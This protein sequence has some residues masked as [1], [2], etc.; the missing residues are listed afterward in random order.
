MRIHVSLISRYR[1]HRLGPAGPVPMCG[2]CIFLLCLST[3]FCL[4]LNF[5]IGYVY[6]MSG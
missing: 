5:N 3:R 4:A 1:I 6:L 2:I